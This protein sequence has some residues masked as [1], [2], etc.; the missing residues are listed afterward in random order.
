MVYLR[1][2]MQL[3]RGPLSRVHIKGAGSCVSTALFLAQD[4]VAAFGGAVT[5]ACSAVAA[6]AAADA[7]AGGVSPAARFA[8]AAGQLAAL[9][10]GALGDGGALLCVEAE[11]GTAVAND[12]VMCLDSGASRPLDAAL[13]AA[14]I[15]MEL[16]VRLVAAVCLSRRCCGACSSSTLSLGAVYT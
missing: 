1:R 14:G 3:L 5:C 9:S 15:Q 10:V 16:H 8:A 6:P 7:D 11:T 4:V 12:E 13:E 2:C